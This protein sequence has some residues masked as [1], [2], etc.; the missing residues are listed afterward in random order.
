M[1]L[2]P[3]FLP[4]PPDLNG[5]LKA[6]DA[7]LL[8]GDAALRVS[9]DELEVLDLA[10]SWVRWQQRPFV[11]AFWACRRREGLPHDLTEIFAQAKY[12]GL[13]RRDELAEV[14][15]RRL[16]LPKDFLLE[17]LYQNIDYSLAAP[18]QEGLER[19]YRLAFENGFIDRAKPIRFL[20]EKSD[21]SLRS[22]TEA[23]RQKPEGRSKTGTPA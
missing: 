7:A 20:V 12:W 2:T 6:C 21:D 19:F 17:Y 16:N 4:H 15:A 5:M 8:I 3:E 18:H 13:E 10:E 9:P 11:F 14:F 22:L 23:R 1:G